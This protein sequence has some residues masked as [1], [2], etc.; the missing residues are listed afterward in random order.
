MIDFN[1]C[2]LSQLLS[3]LSPQFYY[4]VQTKEQ[5]MSY[6]TV[7]YHRACS[8]LGC[9]NFGYVEFASLIKN[10]YGSYDQFTNKMRYNS[11]PLECFDLCKAQN[12]LFLPYKIAQAGLHEARH[13]AQHN[14]GEAVPKFIRSFAIFSKVFDKFTTSEDID[15]STNP[16]EVDARHYAYST[17]LQYPHI[18]KYISH[19]RYIDCERKCSRGC[20]S[21][22][23]AY[24]KVK[25]AL[26][27]YY[28]KINPKIVKIIDD[29]GA[30]CIEFLQN[31]NIDPQAY[32]NMAVQL[33]IR[34]EH[35]RN[36]R[37]NDREQQ[38][39]KTESEAY[40]K[41]FADIIF[42]DKVVTS[43][44]ILKCHD[45]M[46]SLKARPEMIDQAFYGIKLNTYKVLE[47]REMYKEF[48][49]K[50]VELL[51][52]D[53]PAPMP[54]IDEISYINQYQKKD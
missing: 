2:S 40:N 7:L 26:S 11:R 52:S 8:D 50:F 45:R 1:S 9:K 16:L 15:Y 47:T 3:M 49:P 29:M 38:L 44:E 27:H 54:P 13:F 22:Y 20:S 18:K 21:V 17:L 46:F 30:S 39:L 51:S 14:N 53:K 19:Q 32:N 12:N 48:A 41:Q 6:A 34:N 43:E 24:Y 42:N 36:F 25:I 4:Y 10:I 23:Y 33:S 37:Y 35:V 28:G 5:L 31:H